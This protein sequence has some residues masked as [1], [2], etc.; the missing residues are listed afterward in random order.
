[1]RRALIFYSVRNQIQTQPNRELG[2]M[3]METHTKQLLE[4]HLSECE[5]C[6]DNLIKLRQPMFLPQEPCINEKTYAKHAKRAFGKLRR[7]LVAP[8]LIILIL[9]IP[10]TWLGVNEVKGEG[11]SYSSL[12]Y[13]LRGNALLREL[14]YGNYEK[15]F[16]YLN[17]E[18]MYEWWDTENIGYDSYVAEY[19]QQWIN[20]FEKLKEEEITIVG[21]KITLVDYTGGR[22]QL[23]YRLKLNV[24][25]NVNYNYGVTFMANEN[26]FYPNGGSVSGSSMESDKIPIIGAFGYT[27]NI[28]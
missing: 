4:E 13:V 10:L 1:M 11:V 19:K 22:Y 18:P 23:D 24:N 6:K 26:G 20:K 21:Y 28:E 5:C 2:R 17:L 14:K 15:A 9:L 12:T 3:G 16:S 7:R 27:L 8:I 25:G